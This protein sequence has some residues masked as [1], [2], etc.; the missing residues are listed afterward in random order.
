MKD[1]A[2]CLYY[3]LFQPDTGDQGGGD[4]FVTEGFRNWKKKREKLRNLVGD[5]NSAHNM[6]QRKC[7]ALL[8]QRQS[9]QTVINNQSDVEKREYQTRLNASV[10]CICFLQWQG[11]AFRGHDESKDSNNQGKFLNYYGFLQS[12]MKKLIRQSS[13]MLMKIIK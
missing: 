3:Y 2:Y 12:I 11:L 6:A 8:N 5:H 13:K 1:A 9:I 10:D 7:E 4:S